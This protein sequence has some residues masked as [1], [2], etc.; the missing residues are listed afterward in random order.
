MEQEY[1]DSLEQIAEYS[2]ASYEV[3]GQIYCALLFVV[4]VSA[5]L[6]VCILLYNFLKKC[7]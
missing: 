2:L 3:L 5:A 6:G 1:I 4:G 7:Y